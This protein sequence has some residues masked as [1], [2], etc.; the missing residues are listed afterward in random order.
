M[1]DKERCSSWRN[2][3]A[4]VI[5]FRM[6]TACLAGPYRIK[7]HFPR[8]F[9]CVVNMTHDAQ[10]LAERCGTSVHAT[11]ALLS[12]LQ[13]QKIKQVVSLV[14]HRS[15]S[16]GGDIL[17]DLWSRSGWSE[18]YSRGW[19]T[20]VQTAWARRFAPVYCNA[21][22]AAQHELLWQDHANLNRTS[23]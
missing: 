5:L 20:S 1:T 13:Q 6:Q 11:E 22:A 2:D 7:R 19:N 12:I 9:L 3:W 17:T 18:I 8:I 10:S 23:R 16:A 14:V 15:W 4:A 21:P